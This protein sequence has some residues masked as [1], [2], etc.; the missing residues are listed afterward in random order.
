MKELDILKKTK[1]NDGSN[2]NK[3]CE[4]TPW[5]RPVVDDTVS[6]DELSKKLEQTKK[7][8]EEAKN[9]ADQRI[10]LSNVLLGILNLIFIGK[11]SEKRLAA[12]IV[13]HALGLFLTVL[14]ISFL[15]SNKRK[16]TITKSL[17]LIHASLGIFCPGLAIFE[18]M[19]YRGYCSDNKRLK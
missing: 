17:S 13:V 16:S 3:K 19:I 5:S 7:E 10:Y 8:L 12:V 1:G 4:D 18:A 14:S 2:N 15:L 6:I 11:Y 9:D